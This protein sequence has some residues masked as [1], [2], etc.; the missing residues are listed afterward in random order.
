MLN[1]SQQQLAE[2]SAVA[3]KTIADFE[4]GVRAPYARTIDAL[5]AALE[6]AGARFTTEGCVCVGAV[7]TKPEAV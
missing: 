6:V 1:L 7:E 2:A 3:K 4:T 5:R